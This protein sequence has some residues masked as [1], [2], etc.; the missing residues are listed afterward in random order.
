MKKY[1][2]FV[3][4]LAAASVYSIT[5]PIAHA[6][7]NDTAPQSPLVSSTIVVSQFQA[8]GGVAD[9]EFIEIH[10]VGSAPFD[11]NG[12][13]LVY[14]SASGSS[15]V[16]PFAVWA[17][18]T[19]I[20][21]G[22]FYLVTSTTYTG[23]VVADM[24]YNPS[25]CSCSMG[26][27]GGG[28]ALRNGAQNTGAIVDSVGWGSATNA[29][30]E[31]T[32][33]GVPGNSNSEVRKLGGCQDTD[34][35]LNDFQNSVPS[36]PRNTASGLIQCSGGGPSS[37]SGFG[38]ASPSSVAPGGLTLLTVSVIPAS[39]PAS[40]GITVNADLTSIGGSATQ[41]LFDDGTNGDETAGDNLF[42]YFATIP[43][44]TS[45][46]IKSNAIS[47][48]DAQA[49]TASTTI[50]ITVT[51]PV[52]PAEHLAL[53]NP[54]G[55]TT[56]V[57]NP[58][59]YLLVKSQYVVS[60]NRDRGTPNWVAW[61]LDTSWLGSANRQNDFR[62]DPSLP[63]GWYQV[64]DTDYSGSGFDRGH[65]CPSGDRT[66]TVT[67]N[68]ATFFM[69]NMMPQAANNNQGPWANLEIY[70]RTLAGQGNE[71][72]IMAGGTGVGG[73]GLNGFTTTIA[74]GHVTVPATTWKIMVVLPAGSNDLDRITK[75]TR[76]I[77][78]IMPNAQSIGIN[79]PW[80]NFRT[81]V[82]Q[83]E[84][85]TGYSFFTNVRPMVRSLLKYRVDTQ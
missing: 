51:A 16:G 76:V 34:N 29:F 82:R 4:L 55:A 18:S 80:Q 10:N 66:D 56:D 43:A 73:T 28:L 78:V 13:R 75:N 45:G 6:Q 21:P 59:N 61:H 70:A 79:T 84:K 77:A 12:Y 63:A 42:S 24:T 58:L 65:H 62:P 71:L 27:A 32:P 9:D 37:L 23:S 48:A 30:V 14:R 52:D 53:G 64:T 40:T 5:D 44:T 36:S 33:S 47:I 3:A 1:F 20:Q 54:S 15:D 19:V 72:Y 35:N 50:N 74:N 25:T 39:A 7:T 46:G 68:S 67:D 49:R 57:N 85:L 26:A 22:Q 69:T 11:L 81:S 83:V 8:G 41:Q 2:L 60:Y 17:T 31:T 38:A